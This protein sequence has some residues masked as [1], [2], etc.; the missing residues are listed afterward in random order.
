MQ[1][2]VVAG[3]LAMGRKLSQT[4]VGPFGA[5]ALTVW[6]VWASLVLI[7]YQRL[8]RR[9]FNRGSGGKGLRRIN[10]NQT[11]DR[12]DVHK[13]IVSIGIAEDGRAVA[14]VEA[15]GNQPDCIH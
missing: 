14:T 3:I 10:F 4:M 8:C 11:T 7:L 12:M 1:H 15:V 13:A 6:I 2:I 9:S 5:C